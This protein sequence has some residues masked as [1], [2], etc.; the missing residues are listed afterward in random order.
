MNTQLHHSHFVASV[1]DL[2]RSE[3][4][5]DALATVRAERPAFVGGEYHDT[6]AVFFVWAV[7]RLVSAGLSRTQVLWHPLVHADSPLAW[8]STE[9]L[10]SSAARQG[11]VTPTGLAE[12]EPTPVEPAPTLAAA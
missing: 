7:E 10:D 9:V 11:F 8:W 6:R 12:G 2:V 1:V 4:A 5:R 3:G